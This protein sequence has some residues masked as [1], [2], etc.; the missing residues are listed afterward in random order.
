[1]EKHENWGQSRFSTFLKSHDYLNLRKS[2]L[3]TLF[4]SLVVSGC[5]APVQE[6][7]PPPK[8]EP[9]RTIQVSLDSWHAVIAF[10]SG[11][12]AG[13]PDTLVEGGTL[14][15]EWGY[16]EQAWYLEG[17]QGLSGAFRALFLPS[18][19]VVEVGIYDRLWAERTTQPPAEVF[20]FH[21]SEAGYQ[22]LRRYLFSTLQ[23]MNPVAIIGTS[24]FYP[25]RDAYHIFHQCH[26]YAARALRE[27]GLP[28]LTAGAFNRSGLAMQLRRAEQWGQGP[29]MPTP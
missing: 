7:W 9:A 19:G 24:R 16:A 22:R 25:A 4:V 28:V 26:Q 14:Y 11:K 17:R 1:M 6:R 27:S 15:E 8:G 12:N 29:F 13:D 5:A 3:T 20:T 2:T 10:P 23:S 21:L 18:A